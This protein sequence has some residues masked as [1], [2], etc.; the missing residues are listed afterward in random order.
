MCYLFFIKIFSIF[1]LGKYF[2]TSF[3]TF[4]NFSKRE[5]RLENILIIVYISIKLTFT[6]E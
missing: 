2:A 6:L 3:N 1:S 5:I 4:Y